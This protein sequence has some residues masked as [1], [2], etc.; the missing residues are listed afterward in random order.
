MTLVIGLGHRAR[1]GKDFVSKYMQE[2]L[3]SLVQIYS[4][5]RELKLYCKEHHDEELAKWQLA[6]Q[7]KQFP[8]CKTD[9]IYGYTPI[10]QKVGMDFRAT[11]PDYW[12]KKVDAKIHESIEDEPEIAIITDVRFPNEAAYIKEN[13]GY[14]VEVRRL[15]KD[16]DKLYQYVD[17]GRDPKHPS[18]TALNDYN[19]DFVI[20]C[21]DGDLDSLKQKSVHTLN[22]ILRLEAE[23]ESNA[24]SSGYDLS[25]RSDPTGSY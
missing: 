7:T 2:A 3:P 24:N 15:V 16:G 5:A 25:Y 6:N 18:E 17:P 8:A 14:T 4:F 19:F 9:P 23:K 22:T 13:S 1:Q 21:R 20:Q 12:I 10:L 11:D